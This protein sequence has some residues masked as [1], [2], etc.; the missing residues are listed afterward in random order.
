MPPA[1]AITRNRT[2]HER[3]VDEMA[4][5]LCGLLRIEDE[6]HCVLALMEHGFRPTE[7]AAHFDEALALARMA[8]ADGW[9]GARAGAG[10]R[11]AAI[12]VRPDQL[13]SPRR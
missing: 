5:A 8:R 1:T 11:N 4:V 13:S 6:A 9:Q 3:L 2:D 12:A 10:S 7:I